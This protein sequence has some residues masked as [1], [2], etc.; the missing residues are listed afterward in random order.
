MTEPM[1]CPMCREIT[2]EKIGEVKALYLNFSEW[3]CSECKHY[4]TDAPVMLKQQAE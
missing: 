4:Q 1:E 3:E 2:L